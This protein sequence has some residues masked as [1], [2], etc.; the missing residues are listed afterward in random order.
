MD[1]FANV[2]DSKELFSNSPC[3]FVQENV[4]NI[5][6]FAHVLDSKELESISRFLGN[7]NA[8]ICF[9]HFQDPR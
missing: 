9:Q 2:L 5:D 6:S 1:S 8:L 7:Q 3:S 4:P